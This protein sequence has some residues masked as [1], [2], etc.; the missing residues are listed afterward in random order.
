MALFRTFLWVSNIP[1]LL[2]HSSF[3]GHLGCCFHVL[4]VVKVLQQTSGCTCLF[5]LEFSS[6]WYMPRSRIARSY[7]SSLFNFLRNLHTTL[8]VAVPIYIPTSRIGAFRSPHILTPNFNV[9]FSSLK[10]SSLYPLIATSS[11]DLNIFPPITWEKIWSAIKMLPLF[12]FT[13]GAGLGRTGG[14]RRGRWPGERRLGEA[15]R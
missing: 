15:G 6:D 12:L 7:G 1:H 8:P 11:Q 10:E 14:N 13:V 4:A 9:G 3:H 5:Q 2:Y